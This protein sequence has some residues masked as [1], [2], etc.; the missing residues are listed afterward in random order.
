MSNWKPA[1]KTNPNE[2]WAMNGLVFATEQEAKD[3]AH[4]LMTRWL[5]VTDWTALPTED[6]VTHKFR[7]GEGHN[8]N[9][10]I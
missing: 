1:V 7:F 6:P 5:L 2:N 3:S 9:I 10:S 8:G 4:E